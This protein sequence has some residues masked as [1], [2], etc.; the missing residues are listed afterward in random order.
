MI[1]AKI[2]YHNSGHF[3]KLLKKAYGIRKPDIYLN[4]LDTLQLP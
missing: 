3:T 4:K 1:M 2:E